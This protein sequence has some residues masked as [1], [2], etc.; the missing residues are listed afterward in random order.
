MPKLSIVV[1]VYN[2]KNYVKKCID[3]ILCQSYTN[4]EVIIVNDGSSDGAGEICDMYKEIDSRVKVIHKKNEGLISARQTGILC[5]EG[6]YI[7]FVDSD[8]W[9]DSDMYKQLM[10][11][12]LNRQCDIVS[13]GYT[14]VT[15]EGTREE[16][17]ATLF[18]LYEEGRTLDVFFSNMMYD[19]QNERRG[20][21]P[22]LCCKVFVRGLLLEAVSKVDKGISL[23]E[24][25]AVFYPCC[26]NAKRICSLKD[27]KYYY[28][29]RGNSMCR[30][31]DLD[32]FKVIDCFYQYMKQVLW[33]YDDKYSLHN[34]L[35]IYTW[36]F[37]HQTLNQVFNFIVC[38]HVSAIFP[39]DTVERGS[40][41]ILYGA[42]KVGQSYY[43]QL[44]ESKYCNIIAWADKN[45][46]IENIIT[47]EKIRNMDFSKVIIAVYSESLAEEIEKE[48]VDLGISKEKIVW[49]EPQ[50][51]LYTSLKIV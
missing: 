20:I 27:H 34:Q 49:A 32:T 38:P 1:P 18:G 35:K 28:R 36:E 45:S 50:K 47:P 19:S 15:D 40:N 24:D 51:P 2:T 10:S 25:A 23:G 42:G 26:L 29:I 13:M 11:V 21:H 46:N 41:V 17:D 8:D 5:A 39:R 6:D 48:L 9:I 30:F 16:D 37:I 3:S 44:L 33:E 12:A 14:A 7:G 22:S 43:R 31:L 4:L